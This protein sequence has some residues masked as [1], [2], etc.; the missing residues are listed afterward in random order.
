MVMLKAVGSAEYEGS[1]SEFCNAHGIRQKAMKE[2]RKLRVQLTN[3]GWLT[4][5]KINMDH[6]LRKCAFR[7]YGSRKDLD[8]VCISTQSIL[9]PP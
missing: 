6:N 5:S 9:R 2:V 4:D 7:F 1:T 3:A 8:S